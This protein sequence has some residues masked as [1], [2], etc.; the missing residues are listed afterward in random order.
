MLKIMY[1]MVPFKIN[2][3]DVV[4]T[5]SIVDV[6]PM[7]N[8]KVVHRGICQVVENNF[9][10]GQPSVIEEVES[11]VNLQERQPDEFEIQ[12]LMKSESDYQ[13]KEKNSKSSGFDIML[14][15]K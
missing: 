3:T 12:F 15:S 9:S 7:A 8:T 13:K 11:G 10:V 5:C 14:N 2:N 1:L 4:V 6:R